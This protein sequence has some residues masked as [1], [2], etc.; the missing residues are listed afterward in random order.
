M[1]SECDLLESIFSSDRL[2]LMSRVRVY[3][4]GVRHPVS[5]RN[6][7][8]EKRFLLLFCGTSRT[9]QIDIISG[10]LKI[11]LMNLTD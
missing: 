11:S 9:S 2:L 10:H 7:M 6:E 4:S 3:E 5:D 1:T 8:L